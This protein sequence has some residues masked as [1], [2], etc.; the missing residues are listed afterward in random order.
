METML[1]VGAR[2]GEEEKDNKYTVETNDGKDQ[3]RYLISLGCV[4]KL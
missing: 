2:G 1:E 3:A 4:V